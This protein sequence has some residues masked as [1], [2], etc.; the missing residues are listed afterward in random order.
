MKL[1][2]DKITYEPN[3]KIIQ[4]FRWISNHKNLIH[5]KISQLRPGFHSNVKNIEAVLGEKAP[6][7]DF[8]KDNLP[9]PSN[10]ATRRIGHDVISLLKTNFHL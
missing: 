2:W 9:V 10:T 4:F 7:I 6:V 3:V 1:L 5:P 8:E